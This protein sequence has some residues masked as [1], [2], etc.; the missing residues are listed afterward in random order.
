MVSFNEFSLSNACSVLG[1]ILTQDNT[2]NDLIP[3]A[4]LL[5]LL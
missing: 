1:N 5:Y 2:G 3:C 4:Q